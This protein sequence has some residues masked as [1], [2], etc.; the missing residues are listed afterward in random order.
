MPLVR[1]VKPCAFIRDGNGFAAKS[2]KGHLSFTPGF[3]PVIGRGGEERT[4]LTVY[5]SSHDI[6]D[7]DCPTICST[8]L[9]TESSALTLTSCSARA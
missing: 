5:S 8:I 4:V 2:P 3:S 6:R 7:H 1:K 9:S